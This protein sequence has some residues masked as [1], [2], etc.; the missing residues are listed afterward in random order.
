MLR[1]VVREVDDGPERVARRGDDVGADEAVAWDD[2]QPEASATVHK[3]DIP[4]HRF[5]EIFAK[6]EYRSKA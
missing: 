4:D 1:A 2:I 6:F 3:M 5:N